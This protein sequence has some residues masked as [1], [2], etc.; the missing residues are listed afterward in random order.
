MGL[1]NLGIYNGSEFLHYFDYLHT[2]AREVLL[3][4]YSPLRDQFGVLNQRLHKLHSSSEL[5]FSNLYHM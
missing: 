1:I 2:T 3:Y 5:I 4:L